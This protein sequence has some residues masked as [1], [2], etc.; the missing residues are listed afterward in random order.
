[1]NRKQDQRGRSSWLPT[2]LKSFFST[3]H[4]SAGSADWK[5]RQTDFALL[6]AQTGIEVASLLLGASVRFFANARQSRK[7]VEREV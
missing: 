6:A 5:V 1:V 2:R 3:F 4:G 7:R